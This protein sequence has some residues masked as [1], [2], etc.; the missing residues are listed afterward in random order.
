M[1]RTNIC[2]YCFFIVFMMCIP[3]FAGCGYHLHAAGETVG[4][5]IKSLAIPMMTSTSSVLGF[6][7]DFTEVIREEF[8]SHSDVPLVPR[9]EAQMVLLGNI[10]QIETAPLTYGINE[11]QVDNR[12]TYYEVTDSRRLRI[13]LDAKLIDRGTGRVMW[14][15]RGMEEKARFYVTTDPLTN[16]YN[17]KKAIKDIAKRL[18]DRIYLRTVE[19][20]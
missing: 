19:R 9:D 7:G 14:E 11:T 8:I 5:E 10:R 15:E 6:E 13:R 3:F 16:R 1:K 20:F 4:V 18:A 17:E 12:D 2:N